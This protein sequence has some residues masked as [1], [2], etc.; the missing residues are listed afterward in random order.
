MAIGD[1]THIAA[2]RSYRC[3]W[4]GP[5]Q[6]WS[7]GPRPMGGLD[8]PEACVRRV[9]LTRNVSS[10]R[11]LQRTG[12]SSRRSPKNLTAGTSTP[13]SGRSRTSQY[14]PWNRLQHLCGRRN[15]GPGVHDRLRLRL[16][17]SCL[18]LSHRS[19]R[20]DTSR[21]CRARRGR[22]PSCSWVIESRLSLA[23][24]AARILG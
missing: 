10:R 21:L 6:T 3:R 2:D 13:A 9:M 15:A 5:G 18:G 16:Q 8:D 1:R 17:V 20:R 11:W 24:R 4:R 7:L 22:D 23:T 12:R 14:P 19:R